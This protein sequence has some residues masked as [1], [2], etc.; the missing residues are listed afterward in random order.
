MNRRGVPPISRSDLRDHATPERIE[1]IWEQ[2]EA[3]LPIPEPSTGSPS[4][5]MFGVTA[6]VAASLAGGLLLGKLIWDQPLP[7]DV[8]PVA[9]LST[10]SAEQPSEVFAAGSRGQSFALPGGGN[11]ELSPGA[12]VEVVRH[13]GDTLE[14]RL[15]Q[16]EATIDT[17]GSPPQK[18]VALLAEEATLS[19]Q[20]GGIV[21][22]RRS[23]HDMDVSVRDG[24]VNVRSPDG[25]QRLG[26]GEHASAIPIR[27]IRPTTARVA[28]Q[29]RGSAPVEESGIPVPSEPIVA[30][31]PPADWRAA[32]RANDIPGAL[33][34][35]RA[36]PAGIDGAIQSAADPDMLWDIHDVALKHDPAAAMRALM[37]VV[38][39]FPG[40]ASAQ[41]AAFK[42]GDYYKKA[43]QAELSR[44]WYARAAGTDGALAEDAVC[45]LLR[46]TQN[47]QE[48]L[49][50][51][52]EYVAKYP[53]GRCKQDA[54]QVMAGNP[55]PNEEDEPANAPV[56]EDA[57]D[58]EAPK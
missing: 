26:K 35:L 39:A 52:Q 46:S 44:K 57:P 42:L 47:E 13:E 54:E 21:H 1:R 43:G 30:V 40:D 31:A 12:T 51:A 27:S 20:G 29:P 28:P 24:H 25:D 45:R 19:T 3:S 37:R 10:A 32:S 14:L 17:A 4:R 18:L 36:Q 2:V 7:A 33:E 50:L 22:V 41:M 9:T 8:S 11:L 48:A 38:D 56:E 58:A 15:V 16:G 5:L 55:P 49:R 34:M 6:A 53:D 23:D